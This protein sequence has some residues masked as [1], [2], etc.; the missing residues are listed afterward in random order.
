MSN[1]NTLF[2]GKVFHHFDSLESTNQYALN[3]ISKSKPIEGT[4]ISTF[5]QTK[6]RGQIGSNW[7]S[8]INQS[9]TLSIILYPTFLPI[10]RQFILNQIISLAVRAFISEYTSQVVKVKWPND[11]YVNDKKITGILIQ[12]SLSGKKIATTVVGIGINVNQRGFPDDLGKATSLSLETNHQFDLN[13]LIPDLCFYVETQ[14]LALKAG[15]Y[16][17]I[18]QA[19]LKNLYKYQESAQFVRP[20]GQSFEGIIE[21]ITAYGKLSIRHANGLENFDIKEITFK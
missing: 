5:N 6:G 17:Q 20:N 2:I 14:Y 8:G 13:K 10:Q 11:V 4:V 3:L 1:K 19:Y 21:G 9:I 16:E 15:K 18:E 7:E 12:N